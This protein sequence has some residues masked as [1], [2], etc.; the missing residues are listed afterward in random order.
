MLLKAYDALARHV[1]G[2][3]RLLVQAWYS[4][5]TQVDPH[6]IMRFMNYGYADLDPAAPLLPLQATDEDDR[7]CIQL[8]Q[9][10]VA[11]VDLTGLDVLEVGSGRG[12]GASYLTRYLRPRSVVGLDH[13]AGA[14]AFCQRH[15]ADAGL[16]FV[17]GDAEA[18]PFAANQFDVVVNVE[19]SHGYPHPQRFLSEVGRVLRPQGHLLLA[20]NRPGAEMTILRQLLVTS[21]LEIVDEEDITR[22]VV[23]ALDLDDERKRALVHQEMMKLHGILKQI[24]HPFQEFAALKGTGLYSAFASGAFTYYRFALRK[25]GRA[26]DAQDAAPHAALSVADGRP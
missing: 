9:H 21:G 26:C 3:K 14:V 15:Y 16:S 22:N 11:T 8:Y 1:P 20:D 23:R 6:G 24:E 17:V 13:C 2:T 10:T 7:Y 25:P 18:L 12:G 5:L 4:L 19:S